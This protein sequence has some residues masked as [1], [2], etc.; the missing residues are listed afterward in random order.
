MTD[1]PFP[2][3][4]IDDYSPDKQAPEDFE[5]RTKAQPVLSINKTLTMVVIGA[6]LALFIVAFSY[7]ISKASREQTAVV[8]QSAPET[9][10]RN[11][12]NDFYQSLPENYQDAAE[13]IKEKQKA[14]LRAGDPQR[15]NT[16]ALAGETPAGGRE[17]DNEL[18]NTCL[19][20]LAQATAKPVERGYC[21][22]FVAATY[23]LDNPTP[24]AAR[25]GVNGDADSRAVE[26]AL[27]PSGAG[28]GNDDMS[29]AMG[30]AKGDT[31]FSEE[32][33][34]AWESDI[35]ADTGASAGATSAASPA[36]PMGNELAALTN[37]PMPDMNTVAG[38][39]DPASN[40]FAQ[41]AQD[42]KR[43]F[44][45]DSQ[46]DDVYLEH[47]LITPQSPYQVM[48]GTMIPIVLIQGINSD[49]P[50]QVSAQV[51]EHVYD[52]VSGRYVLIPQGSRVIGRY[53]SVIAYGQ[54]RVLVVWNRLILPNGQSIVLEGMPGVDLSGLAGVTG[55]VN[56]HWGRIISGVVLSSL[57]SVSAATS[58]GNQ[59]NNTFSQD[60]ARAIGSEVNDTGQR[61]LE[62]NL[63]IQPTIVVK[64]GES[65]NILVNKDMVLQPYKEKNNNANSTTAKRDW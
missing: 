7:A 44:L 31:Q 25:Y 60:L 18:L 21:K 17:S 11:D 40:M 51:R 15:S 10:M 63:N 8:A 6:V 62:R 1:T 19:K 20:L 38:F 65:A 12:V 42:Q 28:A 26:Y 32:E 36:D 48:A 5:L 52:T 58:Q 29:A 4:N 43:Q 47:Q 54:K 14:A 9:G 46:Q 37:M 55:E 16:D 23:R 56:N 35:V 27:A 61:I 59:N 49:L 50:G 41:N 45:K 13:Y 57:L 39:R 2:S 34:K 22:D 3:D 24:M 33:V 64:P 53:D 30:S